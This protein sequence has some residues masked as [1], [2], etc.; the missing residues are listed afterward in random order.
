MAATPPPLPLLA[1][2]RP[3]FRSKKESVLDALRGAI[4]SG[5]YRPG[6]RLVID[7]LAAQFGIS[8]IPIR[9]ALQ[10]LQADGLVKIEPHVGA[11]VTLIEANLVEEIF[12]LLEALELMSARRAC[13]RM[14]ADQFRQLESIISQMDG[15]LADLDA[16]SAMN[17]RLHT[18]VCECANIPLAQSMLVKVLDHWNRLRKVHLK[19]VH[20]KRASVSQKEHWQILRAMQA[21]DTDLL[22]R[23]IGEHNRA[24]R[25]AYTAELNRA[26]SQEKM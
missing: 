12:D 5:Q 3:L 16:W 23:V 21:R 18:F 8:A 15:M 26:L 20:A 25:D 1:P 17:V 11:T 2:P 6:Q 7:E 14:T 22:E 4:I 10:Q 19:E 13:A 24:A 9:E